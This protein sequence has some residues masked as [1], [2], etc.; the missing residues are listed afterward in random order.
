M[1]GLKRRIAENDA[2]QRF[3]RE[4]SDKPRS[5]RTHLSNDDIVRETLKEFDERLDKAPRSKMTENA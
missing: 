3:R 1:T 2:R 4:I 5:A